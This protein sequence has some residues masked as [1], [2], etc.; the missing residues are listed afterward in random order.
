MQK[1]KDLQS[2]LRSLQDEHRSLEMS[3]KR[4][5]SKY[6]ALKNDYESVKDKCEALKSQLEYY[7]GLIEEAGV[8]RLTLSRILFYDSE[9]PNATVKEPPE[10]LPGEEVWLYAELKDFNIRKVKGGYAVSVDWHLHVSDEFGAEM[11]VLE[12]LSIREV[13]DFKPNVLWFKAK[14]KISVPGTYIAVVTVYDKLSLKTM[15]T[16]NIFIITPRQ[17]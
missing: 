12:P 8:A 3:Y 10:Y 7:E 11:L 2:K 5:E 6:N 4:L 13:Y 17:S 14:V 9:P 15:S 16:A 1:H